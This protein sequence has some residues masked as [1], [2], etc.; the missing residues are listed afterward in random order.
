MDDRVDHSADPVLAAARAVGLVIPPEDVAAVTAHLVLLRGFAAVVG[1]P[2][3][4][5]APVFRP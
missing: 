3:P 1:D 2:D 5:P 4:Q